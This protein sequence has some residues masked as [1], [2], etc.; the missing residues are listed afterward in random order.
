MKGVLPKYFSSEWSFAHFSVPLAQGEKYHLAF[1]E[2]EDNV[3]VITSLGK[4]YKFK[5]E[6][7]KNQVLAIGQNS[8]L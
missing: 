6:F 2:T 5:I 3:V 1:G 8:F 4:Y 7:S